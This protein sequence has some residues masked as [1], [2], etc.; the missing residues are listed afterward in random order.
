M[1]GLSYQTVT[2]AT[3]RGEPH[4]LTLIVKCSLC[5][6]PLC[7]QDFFVAPA[8]LTILQS[9]IF[10]S[11]HK[12]PA[13]NLINWQL[14]SQYIF[15]DL[16][17]MAEFYLSFAFHGVSYWAVWLGSLYVFAS[18]SELLGCGHAPRHRALVLCLPF[19]PLGIWFT[20]VWICLSFLSFSSPWSYF[21]FNSPRHAVPVLPSY[22]VIVD[23]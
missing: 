15:H 17:A 22:P 9:L 12:C 2:W 20:L 5:L 18:S 11:N 13:Y 4:Q 1:S 14:M 8:S 23:M 16:Q 10:S 3:H 6:L 21:P 7:H 19:K